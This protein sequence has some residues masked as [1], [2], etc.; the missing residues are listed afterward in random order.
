[1][2]TST[3]ETRKRRFIA[4]ARTARARW[5]ALHASQQELER[6]AERI[7]AGELAE[8]GYSPETIQRIKEEPDVFF[9][10]VGA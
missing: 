1:M 3:P 4:A 9:R 2:A 8:L 6:A 7:S 10:D 5:Q